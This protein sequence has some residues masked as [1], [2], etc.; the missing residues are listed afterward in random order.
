MYIY[1]FFFRLDTRTSMSQ[2]LEKSSACGAH[3]H[4]ADPLGSCIYIYIYT[5]KLTI[6]KIASEPMESLAEAS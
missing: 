1:I 2:K 4:P 3:E 6:T 5:G